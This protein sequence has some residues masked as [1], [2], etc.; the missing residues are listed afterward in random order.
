MARQA[1]GRGQVVNA[2]LF[3]GVLA[4]MTIPLTRVL[5]GGET[6]S[7]LSGRN[8]CYNLYRCQDGR[9]LAVGALEPKFWEE[10]CGAIGLPQ[11]AG[12]QWD[13]DQRDVIDALAGKFAERTREDWVRELAAHDVCV[14]P[15][16]ELA[17]VAAS[18]LTASSLMD[19]PCGRGTLKTVRT[20]VRLS[21]TPASTRRPAPA[22]GE[23]TDEVLS[24]LGV[25][26]REIDNLR[27]EGVVA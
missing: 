19:Q 23:H 2:S 17:E 5:A 6:T 21:E 22:H 12:R 8:A 9:T 3:D 4:L 27:A 24:E 14:E 11:M 26:G 7:E 13:E 16:L 25:T 1:T 18:P 15:V 10:L 20:P